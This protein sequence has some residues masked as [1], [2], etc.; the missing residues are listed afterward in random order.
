VTK[1][2][3]LVHRVL[4]VANYRRRAMRRP[5]TVELMLLTTVVLWALN[6]TVTRYIL[7]HGMQPLAYATTRYATAAAIFVALT[8]ILERTLR[9]DRQAAGVMAAATALLVTNQLGFVYSLKHTTAS[10]V[11]LV[12][13]AT[14]I[15]AALIALGLGR[16]RVGGR[17]WLGAT[18]SLGGVALVA[19]GA[20]GELSG[21][22]LGFLLAVVTAATW[23]GYSVLI[24]P[25]M[26]SYSPYRVSALVLAGTALALAIVGAPQ[27]ASQDWNL[28]AQ[29]W[30][31]FAFATLGP[32][33]L[34]NVLWFRSLYRIGPARA[35][36]AANLQPF[37]AVI[38]AVILLG[39]SMTAL[40]VAGGVLVA[41]GIV[42][43]RRRPAAPVTAPRPG[44]S[45]GRT[46]DGAG[47]SQ[48]ASTRSRSAPR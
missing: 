39:E 17:F 14:P 41:V 21:D 47:S 36:L 20:G 25:L 38:F 42:L 43:A 22:L 16:E 8:L 29:V 11:G 10:V 1:A 26:A 34:T 12:L 35:T 4:R 2:Q 23:A 46:R 32:L 9:I 31:L 33:V 5:T 3:R 15:F 18:V 30:A 44:R 6:L 19:I 40:Q 7:T 28:G 45:G 48:P 24:A 13:G 27:T 37:V